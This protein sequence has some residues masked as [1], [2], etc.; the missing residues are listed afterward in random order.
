MSKEPS[1]KLICDFVFVLKW[2]LGVDGGK[3]SPV[4]RDEVKPPIHHL[5]PPLYS[6]KDIKSGEGLG[7]NGKWWLAPLSGG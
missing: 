4:K 3:R 6:I 1:A 2:G 5:R 7:G